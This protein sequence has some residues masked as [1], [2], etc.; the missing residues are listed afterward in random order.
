MKLP[1]A[2]IGNLAKMICGDSPYDIFPYRSSSRL[3]EFF[4]GLNLSYRHD[5]STRAGWVKSV[6]DT[7]NTGALESPVPSEE[8]IKVIEGLLDVNHFLPDQL[9]SR[10]QAFEM[11]NQVLVPSSLRVDWDKVTT[12][13]T[14]R[15]IAAVSVSTGVPESSARHLRSISFIPAPNVFTV[16]D[17]N[18]DPTLVSVMMPFSA[19]YAPVLEAI[20]KACTTLNLQC[21]RA[22]D[23]WDNTT[24]IQDIFDLIFQSTIVIVDLSERNPNVLYETGIAHTLGKAVVPIAQSLED[25]PFDLR[26]HRILK[27]LPNNEGLQELTNKLLPRLSDIASHN[28]STSVGDHGNDMLDDLPF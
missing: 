14:L 25:I 9:G 21:R 7:L 11:L 22:D 23:M 10:D 20:K 19:A 16:P 17:K 18:V 15:S 1:D 27:Y 2:T 8:L 6:L 4:Y 13:P 12:Q 28:P 3:T 5:G 24:I 26:S